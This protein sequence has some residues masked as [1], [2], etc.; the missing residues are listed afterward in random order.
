ME[1]AV[2]V[3]LELFAFVFL[4]SLCFDYKEKIDEE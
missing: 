4:A 3:L 2:I 1:Y